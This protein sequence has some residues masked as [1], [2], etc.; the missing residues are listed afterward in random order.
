MV[1]TSGV[2]KC[3]LTANFGILNDFHSQ[4]LRG[5]NIHVQAAMLETNKFE[6]GLDKPSP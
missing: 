4:I 1:R 5:I 3:I 6:G 2:K